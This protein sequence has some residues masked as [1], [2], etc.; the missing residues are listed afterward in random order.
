MSILLVEDH[1]STAQAIARYLCLR[2]YKVHVA[3]DV[4]S[5]RRLAESVRFDLL[6]S[7]IGL[8]DG[9]GWEL[10]RELRMLRTVKAIAMSGY[11]TD[12]DRA[13]SKEAGFLQHLAKPLTP[14]ELDR[15]FE[16]VINV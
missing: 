5:A 11:D 8:P 12:A 14:D 16:H 6:L 10:L 15:A 3:A 7:D 2:G 1:E 4:T 9:T 13:R